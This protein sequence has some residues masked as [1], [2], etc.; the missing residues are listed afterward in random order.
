MAEAPPLEESTQPGSHPDQDGANYQDYHVC[1][2]HDDQDCLQDD[3]PN[4]DDHYMTIAN[5]ESHLWPL[6]QML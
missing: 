1:D 4:H 5:I 6:L 3:H 2:D